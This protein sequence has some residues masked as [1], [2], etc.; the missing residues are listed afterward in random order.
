MAVPQIFLAQ[1]WISC[2]K[3][4]G[5][6]LKD[7][8]LHLLDSQQ[9]FVLASI[10]NIERLT[11]VIKYGIISWLSGIVSDMIGLFGNPGRPSFR[12]RCTRS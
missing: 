7:I 3:K 4:I 8:K 9:R 10:S 1:I 11:H 12:M 6:Y 5:I 2:K